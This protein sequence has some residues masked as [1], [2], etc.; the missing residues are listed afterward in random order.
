MCDLMREREYQRVGPGVELRMRRLVGEDCDVMLEE[1]RAVRV[2]AIVL[3][4]PT[5]NTVSTG[6]FPFSV[7]TLD[8]WL[9][10]WAAND[11]LLIGCAS[12]RWQAGQFHSSSS[13]PGCL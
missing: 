1:E 12:A 4:L 11:L 10:M 8:L 13:R 5:R 2:V 6:G 3:H 7:V 9:T